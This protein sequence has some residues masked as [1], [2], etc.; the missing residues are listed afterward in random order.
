MRNDDVRRLLADVGAEKTL[1]P[2]PDFVDSLEFELRAEVLG[3]ASAI[4]DAGAPPWRLP[5]GI[6]AAAFSV[7]VGVAGITVVKDLP[8]RSVTAQL[9]SVKDAEIIL[10]NGDVVPAVSGMMIREGVIVRVFPNGS[11][12][13][14]G[15]RLEGGQAVRLTEKD[16]LEPVDPDD[17]TG[18]KG[19]DGDD[20]ADQFVSREYEGGGEGRYRSDVVV[21]H[22]VDID[23]DVPDDGGARTTSTQ[24]PTNEREARDV[25]KTTTT[26]VQEITGNQEPSST[27]GETAVTAPDPTVPPSTTPPTTDALSSEPGLVAAPTTPPDISTPLTVSTTVGSTTSTS[28]QPPP[29]VVTIVP[30]PAATVN[31]APPGGTTTTSTPDDVGP[32]GGTEPGTTTPAGGTAAPAGGAGADEEASEEEASEEVAPAS[33][34][35]SGKGAPGD[36]TGGDGDGSAKDGQDGD[37]KAGEDASEDDAGDEQTAAGE[38]GDRDA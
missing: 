22:G 20:G 11:A 31:V 1:P 14:D 6:A 15:V 27:R 33:S 3:N 18:E 25:P 8:D 36:G 5:F 7:V 32:A 24:R 19:E 26:W 30:P 4:A 21:G 38:A 9:A 12:E 2:D 23:D 10:P 29:K 35:P 17:P 37:D 34:T 28:S 13:I 16:S